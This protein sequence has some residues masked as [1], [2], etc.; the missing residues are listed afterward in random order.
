[1]VGL[2]RLLGL[3]SFSRAV[4]TAGDNQAAMCKQYTLLTCFLF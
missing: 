2:S 4:V 3:L 1:M